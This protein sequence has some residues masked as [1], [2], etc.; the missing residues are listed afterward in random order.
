MLQ[1]VNCLSCGA[2]TDYDGGRSWGARGHAKGRKHLQKIRTRTRQ[3]VPKIV[4]PATQDVGAGTRFAT[5]VGLHAVKTLLI[6]ER[7]RG[8]GV[9]GLGQSTT[10]NKSLVG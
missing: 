7:P 6:T 4:P 9:M 10:N 1:G 8:S 2:R 3:G 5:H